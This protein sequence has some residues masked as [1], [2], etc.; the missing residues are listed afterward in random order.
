MRYFSNNKYIIIKFAIIYSIYSANRYYLRVICFLLGIFFMRLLLWLIFLVN[1]A[2]IHWVNRHFLGSQDL[3]I[4][5]TSIFHLDIREI[6]HERLYDCWF[7]LFFLETLYLSSYAL[8]LHLL[9]EAMVYVSLYVF[10]VFL[11]YI[12]GRGPAQSLI[13]KIITIKLTNIY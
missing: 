1:W 12:I 6:P 11:I 5:L 3:P 4:S 8:Y 2:C 7:L 9:S 13:K 10:L